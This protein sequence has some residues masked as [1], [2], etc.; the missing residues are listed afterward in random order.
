MIYRYPIFIQR[1]RAE[2]AAEWSL[3]R[4]EITLEIDLAE[5]SGYFH[6]LHME[7]DTEETRRLDLGSEDAVDRAKGAYYEHE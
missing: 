2:S 5:H 7:D 6:A 3:G 1:N 4:N